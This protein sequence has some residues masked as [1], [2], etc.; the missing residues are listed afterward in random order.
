MYLFNSKQQIIGVKNNKCKILPNKK[1]LFLS[2][3]KIIILKNN[4]ILNSQ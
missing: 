3:W 1:A 4:D 2:I